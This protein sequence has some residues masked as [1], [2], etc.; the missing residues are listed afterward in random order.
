MLR[1][2]RKLNDVLSGSASSAG[3]QGGEKCKEIRVV[4]EVLGGILKKPKH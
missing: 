3:L 1:Q 2:A 4:D